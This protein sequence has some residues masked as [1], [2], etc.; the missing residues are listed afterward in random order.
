MKV[1]PSTPT[2]L[3][4]PRLS[5]DRFEQSQWKGAIGLQGTIE[6]D[7]AGE[8]TVLRSSLIPSAGS[9]GAAIPRVVLV[10]R[11]WLGGMSIAP[12]NRIPQLRK[13]ESEL[14]RDWQSTVRQMTGDFCLTYLN[15]EQGTCVIYRCVTST[16]PVYYRDVGNGINWAMDITRLFSAG[17][18]TIRDVD[19]DA[20][21]I[22]VSCEPLPPERTCYRG[23]RKI[24]PGSALVISK[25]GVEPV[26]IDKLATTIDLTELSLRDVAAEL[27]GRINEAVARAVSGHD[28]IGVCLSGGIDSAVVLAEA[29]K[30]VDRTVAFHGAFP[31]FKALDPERKRAEEV[32]GMLGVQMFPIEMSASIAIGGDLCLTSSYG[33]AYPN[34]TCLEPLLTSFVPRCSEQGISLVVDGDVGDLLFYPLGQRI[35]THRVSRRRG[36]LALFA[37]ILDV[38]G[39]ANAKVGNISKL[40][41]AKRDAKRDK[42]EPATRSLL[43]REAS[44]K[45]NPMCPSSSSSPQDVIAEAFTRNVDSYSMRIQNMWSKYDIELAHPFADRRL[46]EYCASLPAWHRNRIYAGQAINKAAL[47]AAYVDRLPPSVIRG[48]DKSAYTS[49]HETYLRENRAFVAALLDSSSMLAKSGIIEDRTALEFIRSGAGEPATLG[50]IIAAAGVEIWLRGLANAPLPEL[51]GRT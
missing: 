44:R 41:M 35:Y 6:R 43:T 26:L 5:A 30:L 4:G 14:D 8:V 16:R 28:E 7:R 40:S 48:Y 11:A 17:T 32:T 2:C 24:P 39:C 25:Y 46:I 23:V 15:E 37:D 18:P 34:L 47:R 9:A 33:Q 1:G 51:K 27:R 38:L 31:Q 13:L 36:P 29:A 42:N 19:M 45:C 21:P 3:D 12:P 22:L 49:I 50:A 10:G 20:I